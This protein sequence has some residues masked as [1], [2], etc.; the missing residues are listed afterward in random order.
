[1]IRRVLDELTHK[2]KKGIVLSCFSPL[3]MIITFIIE[4]SLAIYT[5]I[6]SRKAKSD[7]GIVLVLV[8]LA[9]FQLAEYQI[10]AGMDMLLWSRIGLF[11]ITFLPVLGIYLIS[12]LHKES[13]LLKIGFLLAIAFVVFFLLIPRTINGATC[14]GNYI[15]FDIKSSC[16]KAGLKMLLFSPLINIFL[17]SDALSFDNI[18]ANIKLRSELLS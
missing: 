5:F 9:T 2:N 13:V 12:K 11:A 16:L 14:G 6:K 4:I 17:L 10:C 1:M 7:V 18:A 15:I 8:F 3:V